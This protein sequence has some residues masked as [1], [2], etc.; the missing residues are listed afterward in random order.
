[1]LPRRH[2]ILLVLAL[3]APAALPAAAPASPRQPVAFEA[4]RELLADS[5]R[6]RTLDEIRD[7]GVTDIRQLVYW[8]SFAPRPNAK[9]KPGGRFVASDPATYPADT[10]APLDAL[11]RD[12]SARGIR[13]H[14]NLTGPVPRWATKSRKDNV[15]RPSP[16]EFQAWATAVG[17]RYGDAVAT[18]SIWNEPN[19]PQFLK[20]QYRNG[21][22]VLARPLPAALPGRRA[23]AQEDGR[24]PRRHVPD[25]R[26]LAARQLEGRVPARLLPADAVPEQLLQEDEEVRRARRRRLRAPRLHDGEGPAVRPARH[27]RRDARRALAPGARAR[28]RRQG[29]ARSRAGCRST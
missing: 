20:P 3:A 1:M 15:T 22:A 28:P 25:R 8:R 23:R 24:Q 10:W 17:R 16:K 4:P 18:W 2:T 26:D 21:Q 9:R 5:T 29:R 11:I 19:Q 14:L 7:F 13:V 6:D 12:A 27:A